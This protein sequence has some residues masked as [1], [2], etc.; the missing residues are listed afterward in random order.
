MAEKEGIDINDS[1]PSEVSPLEEL[2][3]NDQIE[4]IPVEKDTVEPLEVLQEEVA[5]EEAQN[6]SGKPD[7]D[8]FN[9]LEVPS[10]PDDGE[11]EL[12][13][14]ETE[15]E[16][17]SETVDE[18]KDGQ[19]DQDEFDDDDF[20]GLDDEEFDDEPPEEK[21]PSPETLTMKSAENGDFWK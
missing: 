6:E 13:P 4:I 17:S 8:T 15:A 2:D 7:S 9:E 1:K 21:D 10:S 18:Q 11:S 3:L 19:S 12:P 5:S 20:L 16:K 14:K